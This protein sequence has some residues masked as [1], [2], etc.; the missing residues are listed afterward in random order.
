MYIVSACLAGLRTRYDGEDCC[1]RRIQSLVAKGRAIPLCPEQLGGLPTPREAIE[2][3][4]GN[5]ND[6]LQGKAKI[7]GKE[8]GTDYTSNLLRGAEEVLKI[9]SLL[10][11]KKAILK[12][13]SPSCGS[14]YIKKGRR[15][16]KGVGVTTAVLLKAGIKVEPVR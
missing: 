4:G 15:R 2:I 6:I 7:I 3:M 10:K 13:G 1:D 11:I 14:T 5:G 12:D 8:S 16:I 9:A